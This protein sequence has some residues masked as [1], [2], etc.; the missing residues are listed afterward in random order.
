MKEN[1][2]G[3]NENMSKAFQDHKLFLWAISF[4]TLAC[5]FTMPRNFNSQI[6][7]SKVLFVTP[8]F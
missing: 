3:L 6:L 5:G 7:C 4:S 2:F 1:S 8:M